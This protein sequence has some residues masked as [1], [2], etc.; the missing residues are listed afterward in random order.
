MAVAGQLF[1]FTFQTISTLCVQTSSEVHPTAYKIGTG[2]PFPGVKRGRSVTLIT[3]P[4][5][6]EV[7]NE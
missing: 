6:C 4:I 3:H 7:M 5:Y 1:F 2:D